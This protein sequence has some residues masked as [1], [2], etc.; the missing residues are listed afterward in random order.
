MS[1]FQTSI[2]VPDLTEAT[3]QA[4]HTFLTTLDSEE[5]GPYVGLMTSLIISSWSNF[6]AAATKLA[7]G[8]LEHLILGIGKELGH[9]L[10]AVAD[11]SQ[12]I[13]LDHLDRHIKHLRRTWSS[14]NYLE[15]ILERSSSENQTVA[16][17][18]LRELKSFMNNQK[19]FFSQLTS[20]DAFDPAVGRLMETLVVAA[21]REHEGFDGL[22]QLAFE[23]IGALGALDPDRFELPSSDSTMVVLGNYDDDE[24]AIIFSLHLIKDLL[25]GVFRATSDVAY[26]KHLGFTLQQLLKVCRFTPALVNTGTGQSVPMKVRGRWNSLPKHVI[27]TVS[28]LLDSKYSVNTPSSLRLQHPIYPNQTTYREWIQLWTCHLITRVSGGMARSIFNPFYA[29]AR[30]KDVVVAYHILPHL[31]LNVLISGGESDLEA[32]RSE[33]LAVLQDQPSSNNESLTDKKL[34][35]AQVP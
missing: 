25:V 27:E 2:L 28:P 30:N 9:H 35:S 4:W 26:Q 11:L 20:G 5:V 33:L 18:G 1:I 32:I 34:L 3:L 24:E 19:D 13:E 21:C 23:L 8:L 14:Q 10:D 22:R 15:R 16:L 29:A 7:I 31:A 12:I 17:Q 6:G